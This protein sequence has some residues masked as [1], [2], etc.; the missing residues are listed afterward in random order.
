MRK[1]T[2]KLGI[3]GLGC[4][5]ITMLTGVILPLREEGV[6]V[7]AVCDTCEDR[8]LAAA[9]AVEGAGVARPLVTADY[10]EVLAIEE[11]D[12]VYIATAWEAHVEIAVAAMKAGK[13][14]GLEVGGAYSV[15]DC[16]KLVNTYE[17]TGTHCMLLENCCYGKRELMALNM[18]RRG[19][20]GEIVHCSGAYGHDLRQEVVQGK[21]NRH[22]R[23]RNYLTR[24]CE[25]YPTHELGPI[26]KL[27]DINNG[28]KF[29]SLSSF[30]SAAKGLHQYI[31][32]KQGL[33]RPLSKVNFAQGDIITTV[34]T[35]SGGQTVTITLDTTLPRYYTRS[36]TVRGT[37]GSYFEENDSVFLDQVHT[38]HELDWK[39]QW[40]NAQE[41]EEA[42]LHPLWQGDVGADMHGGIDHIVAKA[43]IEAIKSNTRP[44]ID[45]YDAATYM[46]VAALSEQ[47]I[48]LGGAPMA[49]PDFTNGR[50]TMRTDIVENE[51][52][53]DRID[54]GRDLYFID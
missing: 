54:N 15:A 7:I 24:N 37:K 11:L 13:Y 3:I 31:V 44:P 18:V 1:E 23:L 47:S 2:V 53:L 36:F 21:E 9:D 38:E 4:R 16:Y 26:A 40:G 35:C 48:T 25:N 8:V 39:K 19:L 5:G 32:E 6:E 29:L 51:Y 27:L 33:Y 28:N 41:Y 45:V 22:Y 42:Y 10:R 17:E 43:F 49:F 46:C 12:A 52:T 34:L 30:S 14:V 20:F 50:W